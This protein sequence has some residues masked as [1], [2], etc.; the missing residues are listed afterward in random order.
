MNLHV[1]FIDFAVVAIVI[2]STVYAVYRGFVR[3]TLSIFAL[4]AAAFASL[5]FAPGL[6][7]FLRNWTSSPWLG[8][9]IAYAAVFLVVLIPLS[10]M[11]YRFS[12]SVRRSP[13]GAIDRSLGLPFGVVRG[14]VIVG[15]LYIIFGLIVPIPK[16]PDW[17]N[18]A[19]L[20]PLIQ[21]S[22]DVLLSLIPDRALKNEAMRTQAHAPAER[23]RAVP[24]PK[25]R[26]TA[27]KRK[28]KTYGVQDR[29]SLDRLI[30]STGKQK[31]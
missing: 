24:A 2:V 13:V 7:P 21:S 16:Q 22:S 23:P 6:V 9:L 29:E 17:M 4:I 28:A 31:P 27:A 1:T 26:E 15:L 14:L 12:E 3:E 8:V 11:S 18:N 20:L 30:Q 25:P 5:Y 19:R 10:F